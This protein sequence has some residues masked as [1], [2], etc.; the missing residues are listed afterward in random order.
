MKVPLDLLPLFEPLNEKLI[1]F[2]KSLSKS[3]WERQTIA[4]KWKVK[5][6]ASHLLDGNVR[7]ISIHRDGFSLAPDTQIGT[8]SDLVHFLNQL[9]A[10]WVKA[11]KRM[12]PDMIIEWLEITNKQVFKVFK[13]LKP[14]DKAIYSV[15]W[16]GEEESTNWFDIARE[17]T[18]R[19]I[20]QQQIRNAFDDKQL[21]KK[22]Y[23]APMLDT[24]MMA[25]PHT[26]RKVEAELGTS[27][28]VHVGNL[29]PWV[30][31]KEAGNWKTAGKKMKPQHEVFVDPDFAWKLF[32][33]SKRPE[34]AAG[35]VQYKGDQQLLSNALNL[36]SVMA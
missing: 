10:D 12:S 2:L 35:Y 8:Y 1:S 9:N 29:G 6:V 34:E 18:E 3:D 16:A 28:G 24:F 33:R 4:S 21:L 20:H 7:R 13:K 23:Y 15:A 25:L 11:M 14:F 31:I 27:L 26:Y 32:S 36:V 22:K 19:W 17:Y 5:D 30:I